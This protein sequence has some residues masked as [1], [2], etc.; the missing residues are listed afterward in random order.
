FEVRLE[1]RNV[2]GTINYHKDH[3]QVDNAKDIIVILSATTN[4]NGFDKSPAI[5][6]LNMD[7][8]LHLYFA[9]V[10]NLI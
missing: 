5:H 3:I 8:I 4:F 1:V 10:K 2:G 7:S 9:K 6:G